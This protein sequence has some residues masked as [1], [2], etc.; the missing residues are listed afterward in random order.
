MKK[1]YKVLEVCS[2]SLDGSGSHEL[3]IGGEFLIDETE[4]ADLVES[5]HLELIEDSAE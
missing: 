4:A 3:P 5:G 2:L 1:K